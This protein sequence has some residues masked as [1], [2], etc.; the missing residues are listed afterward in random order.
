MK[1]FACW[2]NIP[3]PA[4]TIMPVQTIMDNISNCFHFDADLLGN[5]QCKIKGGAFPQLQVE[6]GT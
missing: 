4:H 6:G 2:G 5:F 1:G 3:V